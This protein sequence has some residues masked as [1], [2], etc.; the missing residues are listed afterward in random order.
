MATVELARICDVDPIAA[1]VSG[2]TIA[3]SEERSR[4]T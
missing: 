3:V 1:S 4:A 2:V